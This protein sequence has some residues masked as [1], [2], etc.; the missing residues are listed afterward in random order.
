MVNEI[1]TALFN[2][3]PFVSDRLT[4]E[5]A[6]CM[7]RLL[8]TEC[9]NE[10][11]QLPVFLTDDSS[12]FLSASVAVRLWS[13]TNSNWRYCK[14]GQLQ[15]RPSARLLC[16]DSRII[17][18]RGKLQVPYFRLGDCRIHIYSSSMVGS[19]TTHQPPTRICAFEFKKELA[20]RF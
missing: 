12:P 14:G 3:R 4:A 1:R 9:C 7:W 20:Y 8:P 18:V 16:V 17:N 11:V 10:S 2:R 19:F 13:A 5:S 15:A 6:L